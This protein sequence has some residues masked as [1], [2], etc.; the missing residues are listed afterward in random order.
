MKK[1]LI[2][3]IYRQNAI[4]TFLDKSNLSEDLFKNSLNKKVK[5]DTGK[6]R[7][8]VQLVCYAGKHLHAVPKYHDIESRIIKKTKIKY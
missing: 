3:K 5:I 4:E 8:C 1:K 7:R 6:N 2:S